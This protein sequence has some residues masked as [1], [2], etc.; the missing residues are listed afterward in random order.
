M[1]SLCLAAIALLGVTASAV[2]EDWP[3][4]RGPNRDGRWTETGIIDK[5]TE[6]GPKVLW[7]API[8]GGYSGPAVADGRVFVTDFVASGDKPNDPGKRVEL[9]G[10]ER[11]LA[12]D[13]NSGKLLWTHAEDCTY[14]I[15]YPAGPRVTPTVSGGKV[16]SIGSEGR[17][18]CLD[19]Q[20]GKL[21]WAHDFP[22][23]YSVETPIWGHSAHPLIDGQKL[24]CV[25]GGSGSV[26]VAFDKDHGKELWRAL[27]SKEPGY[28]APAIIQAGGQ[29][30]LL[31]WHPQAVNSLNPETGKP[32]WS[33]P[34]E[35]L[36][37]MSIQMPIQHGDFLY[38]G[39]I[40]DR[41]VCLKLASDRPAAEEVW[42]GTKTTGLF[43]TCGTLFCDD[44]GI[45]YGPCQQGHFR[46]VDIKTGKRLWESFKPTMNGT[47]FAS[48]GT[49][50]V[51][52]NGERY[53]LMS[54]TGDLIIA[55]LSGEG[56]EELS[57]AHVID[58]TNEAFGRAVVWSHPAFANKTMF[59]RNDKE[60][61]AI[62]L[63]KE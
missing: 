27:T 18:I 34:L 53:F 19:A 26:A 59:M 63:A 62:H 48:S 32:H 51:V 44:Q 2:G 12:F 7:R 43:P 5:F 42:R 1:V 13:A 3:Q 60:I 61:V 14:R 6:G 38:A 55:R 30:Q 8:S 4:W 24:I 9:V 22:K 25:V 46:A 16:Y 50:F 28:C 20:T 36:Y 41:G 33:V 21:L 57:R 31:I 58:A 15:S 23:D 29:R 52:K 10:Q 40:G 47:R 49:C 54:E 11:L 45:L 17:L 35:P 37:G 39:G 56:Y